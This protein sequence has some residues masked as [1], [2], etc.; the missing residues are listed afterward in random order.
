[1]WETVSHHMTQ[2][3]GS[4]GLHPMELLG[5]LF[6][7]FTVLTKGTGFYL[8]NLETVNC[9]QHAFRRTRDLLEFYRSG[10][11]GM[12]ELDN[13][14]IFSTLPVIVS[15]AAMVPIIAVWDSLWVWTIPIKATKFRPVEERGTRQERQLR[16]EL[17][18]K[19]SVEISDTASAK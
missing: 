19:E 4:I 11:H 17:R 10:L 15:G 8:H 16:R 12:A 13:S 3:A 6:G 1:M 14:S 7:G 2:L 18:Q 5:I 9:G